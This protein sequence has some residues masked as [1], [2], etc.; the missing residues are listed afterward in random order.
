MEIFRSEWNNEHSPIERAAMAWYDRVKNMLSSGVSDRCNFC[1]E[2]SLRGMSNCVD[3]SFKCETC[4]IK[5]KVEE[6][7]ADPQ[8]MREERLYNLRRAKKRYEANHGDALQADD[9]G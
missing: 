3:G 7:E 2:Y 5:A 8:M 4:C 1:G 6:L 9:M